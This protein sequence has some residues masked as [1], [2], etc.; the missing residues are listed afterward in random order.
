MLHAPIK[1]GVVERFLLFLKKFVA[2]WLVGA[3][4]K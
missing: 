3:S 4:N 2:F 1:T